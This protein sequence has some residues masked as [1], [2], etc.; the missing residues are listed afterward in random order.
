[1]RCLLI[2]SAMAAANLVGCS[3]SAP[4]APIYFG[5]VAARSGT[6]KDAGDQAA[7][8]IRL[9][10][11]ELNKDFNLR[12]FHVRHVDTQ[13]N[14]A[15]FESL[16]VRLATINRVEAL[17]GAESSEEVAKLARA[18]ALV[19]SAAGFRPP[20]LG[21]L[22]FTTGL[23]PQAQAEALARFASEEL[24]QARWVVVVDEAREESLLLAKAFEKALAAGLPDPKTKLTPKVV[25]IP[26]GKNPK[27]SEVGPRVL[28]EN[29]PGVLLAGR[30]SD[31]A[32]LLFELG[33]PRALTVLIGDGDCR[34]YYATEE[35][36]IYQAT[37]FVVAPEF[38]QA[39]AFAKK[40]RDAFGT[41]PDVHAAH[42]YEDMRLLGEAA[43]RALASNEKLRDELSNTKD[44]AGLTGPASFG[45]DQHL[46]RSAAV[47]RWNGTKTTLGKLYSNEK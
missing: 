1:M 28:L 8:G 37:T 15:A 47:V 10:L 36:P 24:H 9:A 25:T 44:F 13:G 43:R 14:V 12:P 20:N 34:Q 27:M 42:G 22:V 17:I 6:G 29:S 30:A 38:A 16:G 5:H 35:E 3:N 41:E 11:E 7:R 32:P 18:K 19:I 33:K 2:L 31:L 23:T 21:D 46:R 39:E 40:F 45:P 4:P 26:L